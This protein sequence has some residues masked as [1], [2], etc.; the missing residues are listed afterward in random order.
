MP[1]NDK[2]S[3][4]DA[5]LDIAFEEA[6]TPALK[7]SLSGKTGLAIIVVVPTA[8]WVAPCQTFSDAL[9]E[10]RHLSGEAIKALFGSTSQ[11]QRS[12]P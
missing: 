1:L 6:L 8:A 7:R 2:R 3:P 4:T 5:I 10:T 9:A 12:K 11:P